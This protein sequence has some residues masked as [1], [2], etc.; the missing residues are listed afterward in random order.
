MY[1]FCMAPASSSNMHV[2]AALL[3]FARVYATGAPVTLDLHLPGKLPCN[4]LELRQLETAHAIVNLWL[5]LSYRFEED[6]FPGREGVQQLATDICDLLHRGLRKVT[7][8]TK[9]SGGKPGS[10]GIDRT[11]QRPS[12]AHARLLQPFEAQAQTLQRAQLEGRRLQR[13]QQA[14][15][16]GL[17]AARR[18]PQG[19]GR[20]RAENLA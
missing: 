13:G 1:S 12:P 8:L 9:A 19:G 10:R 18:P 2:L 6:A 15:E 3:H 17:Q 7:S 4:T 20:R 11:T 16:R 14:E 5:W